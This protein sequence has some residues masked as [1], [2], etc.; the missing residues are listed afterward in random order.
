MIRKAEKKDIAAVA[1]IY[2]AIHTE[3]EQGKITT[4]WIRGIY[5]TLQTAENALGA[6]ELYVLEEAGVIVAA[7]RINGE[8]DP[9]YGKVDWAYPAKVEEVLVLHTLVVHPDA[10][11]K[12]CGGRFVAFYEQLAAAQGCSVLRMDTNRKNQ[13]AREMYARRGYREA[14]L[15]PCTFNGLEGIELI[16]LEKKI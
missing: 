5:P 9:A 15:V 12:G 13:R 14:G 3:E 4:G 2:E 10:G 11:G 1:A 7:A 8:Q 16:C 6:G